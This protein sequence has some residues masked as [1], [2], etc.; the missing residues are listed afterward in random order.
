[1]AENPTTPS[2]MPAEFTDQLS[3]QLLLVPDSEFVLARFAYSALLAAQMQDEEG[4]DLAMMQV[5]E[6]RLAAGAGA[7]AN[8]AE[9]MSQGMGG[10][11]LLSMGM[12]FPDM[13]SMVREA[14]APGENIKINRPRFIDGATTE[15]NRILGPN[16]SIFGSSS[17]QINMDQ[18][19]VTVKEYS[20]P[21]DASGNVVPINLARF[22]QHRSRH[23]LLT[24]CGY[25][26]RRDRN[27]LVDDT[28]YTRLIAAADASSDGVTRG[29]DVAS[30]AAFTGA[31]NEPCSFDVLVKA[32]EKIKGRK[33]PGIGGVGRYLCLLDIHQA[34]QLKL[35]PQYQRLS[36]FQPEFN[37]LFP[38]YLR[39]V[40]DLVVCMVNRMPR[41]STLGAGGN[42]TGYQGLIIAPGVLGWASAMDAKVLRDRNDDG[43]RF[44]R[45]AWHAYE[46]WVVLNDNFVQKI[47]TT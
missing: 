41:L 25:E 17:Q 31:D 26:L 11:L 10:P 23:D 42:L 37:P 5:R 16:A 30:N 46:G 1:M 13:V 14:R 7:P 32:S 15:A 34:T 36:V 12:V 39:T 4:F 29:G 19:D 2:N 35:D 43:G 6:G 44:N 27:K 9:A 47:I 28:C 22:T 38:G 8:I 45:F 33:V 18:V 24:Q 20:G 3:E 21:G 40:E